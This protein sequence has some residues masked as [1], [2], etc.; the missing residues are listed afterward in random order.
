MTE[1][2]KYN[3]ISINKLMLIIVIIIIAIIILI[4]INLKNK[5]K[6]QRL[7]I[8]NYK[9][10]N[11]PANH[12]N[13]SIPQNWVATSDFGKQKT[14][15]NTPN[16]EVTR[17]EITNLSSGNIGLTI[18]IY[19]KKPKCEWS[20]KPNTLLAGMPALYDAQHYSWT[21]D[22]DKSAIVVGYYYPGA[23]V[24][25]RRIRNQQTVSR[26]EI[27]ANREIINSIL[28]TLKFK[29]VQPLQCP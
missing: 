29:S 6:T 26:S 3:K 19:E 21:I 13:I 8:T 20:D 12:F 17:T 22:T 9:A 28:S 10:Y 18:Y 24:Y 2:I 27:A 11:D 1:A 15:I 25:H 7:N 23:G 16:E 14:G 5:P 4:L